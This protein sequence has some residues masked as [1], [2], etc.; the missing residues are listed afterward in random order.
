M[1]DAN[2]AWTK[3]AAHA[4]DLELDDGMGHLLLFAR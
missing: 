4:M 3:A 2:L 1:T